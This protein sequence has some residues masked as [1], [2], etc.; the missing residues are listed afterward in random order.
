MDPQTRLALRWQVLIVG[1]VSLIPLAVYVLL[2]ASSDPQF[3]TWP[4]SAFLIVALWGFV[5]ATVAALA[6]ERIFAWD[7]YAALIGTSVIWLP[8]LVPQLA[9]LVYHALGQPT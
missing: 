1:L 9:H 3:G 8:T 7:F 2:P 5:R 6:R 4:P